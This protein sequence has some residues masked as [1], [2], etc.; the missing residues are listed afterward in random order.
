MRYKDF[1]YL[2]FKK[3][4]NHHHQVIQFQIIITSQL[5]LFPF[6]IY[7][8]FHKIITQLEENYRNVSNDNNQ[9]LI[10]DY[11]F[12]SHNHNYQSPSSL[13]PTSVLS[14]SSSSSSSSSYDRLENDHY[15]DI[16]TPYISP[17]NQTNTNKNIP[18]LYMNRNIFLKSE[19]FPL[20]GL[21]IGIVV[22]TIM[23]IS[24]ITILKNWLLHRVQCL[25]KIGADIIII[26]GNG[27]YELNEEIL[28]L[29]K[30]Y[31]H[32]II[33]ISNNHKYSTNEASTSKSCN[34]DINS[35][36]NNNNDSDRIIQLSKVNYINGSHSYASVDFTYHLEYY[37]VTTIISD[38]KQSKSNIKQL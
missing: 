27:N 13:S 36:Q 23:K 14:S 28:I 10:I 37:N 29:T 19:T 34:A 8:D 33:G 9:M 6:E 26:I 2:R 15:Y 4:M 32:L 7:E 11:E 25:R 22:Y 1:D 5:L 24:S 30:D 12:N 20:N 17:W 38:I 16:Y 31:V 21:T 3:D 35:N 18:L